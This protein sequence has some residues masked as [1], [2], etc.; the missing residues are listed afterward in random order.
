MFR[1]PVNRGNA[2]SEGTAPRLCPPCT[3]STT[4]GAASLIPPSHFAT[5]AT[6][7]EPASKFDSLLQ[8]V[9]HLR[10]ENGR[11]KEALLWTPAAPSGLPGQSRLE[12]A[13]TRLQETRQP[14]E[15]RGRIG[16][17]ERER[18]RSEERER[19]R[20]EERERVRREERVRSEERERVRREERVRSEERERVRSEE[21]VQTEALEK[22]RSK[23]RERLRG[24]ERDRIYGEELERVRGE[25]R[26]RLRGEERDRIYGEELERV[27]GEE[28]ERLRGEE[29]DRIYSEEL[30]KVRGEERE[31]LRGEERDRIYGEELERVR[32]EERERLRGEERDRIYSEELEKVRGEER[33]R[34]RG[35]ERD[36]IYGEELERVRGEERER[37]RGEEREGALHGERE[38]RERELCRLG[39]LL[40]EM[41]RREEQLQQELGQCRSE[42]ASHAQLVQQMRRYV[43]T[44]AREEEEEEEGP[45]RDSLL[46][47]VQ[48][49]DKENSRLRAESEL[50]CLRLSSLSHILTT[51][52]AIINP[53][54]LELQQDLR[55]NEGQVK[56]LELGLSD[57]T[58]ELKLQTIRAQGLQE[59]LDALKAAAQ[60]AQERAALA[61]AAVHRLQETVS[62]RWR[63]VT[64]GEGK[65]VGAMESLGRLSERIRFATRRVDLVRGLVLR[66]DALHRLALQEQPTIAPSP[67]VPAR[68][69]LQAELS[70]LQAERDLL[71][72][73]MQRDALLLQEKISLATHRAEEACAEQLRRLWSLAEERG[74]LHEET[75]ARLQQAQHELQQAQHELEAART[76][77]QQQLEQLQQERG[78]KDQAVRAVERDLHARYAEQLSGLEQSLNQAR[79]EHGKAVVAL[80]QGEREWSRER[81]RARELAQARDRHHHVQL[82]QLQSHLQ[83]LQVDGSLMKATLRQEGLLQQ[84]KARRVGGQQLEKGQRHAGSLSS[85]LKDL[86]ALSVE[87]LAE[88]AK[89][90]GRP[91]G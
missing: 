61:E 79:R 89:Q 8:E 66:R 74:E 53:P 17:E 52:E 20:S 47:R 23:E 58:A 84:Y 24:E 63:E 22:V 71:S 45:D 70:H 86:K 69:D 11:L 62:R 30:E 12:D 68:P 19:V 35:E 51:Q 72:S 85:V 3:F 91:D 49:L 34:L 6:P 80:R 76:Q 36:R 67:D 14:H 40:R 57:R 10:Q 88:E 81:E 90:G 33:E 83:Q 38:E 54:L 37:L 43:G 7:K 13:Q 16:S 75:Q 44:R 21:R 41:E 56:L 82:Q 48:V 26:E 39:S 1:T 9:L 27:R 29:R 28:R 78:A 15:E 25:E 18:V 55:K 50:Q 46:A 60:E 42:A 2:G 77:Q 4:A 64:D 73:Q 59:D 87:A 32:G 65:V 5:P 31:R